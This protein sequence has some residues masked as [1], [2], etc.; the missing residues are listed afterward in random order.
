ME[1]RRGKA[2]S[3]GYGHIVTSDTRLVLYIRMWKT[4]DVVHSNPAKQAMVNSHPQK[5]GR[6]KF[7]DARDVENWNHGGSYDQL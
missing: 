4:S 1:R 2:D 6:S 3:R 7:E 5:H